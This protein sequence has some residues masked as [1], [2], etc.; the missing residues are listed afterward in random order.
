MNPAL[1]SGVAVGLG[2]S[3]RVGVEVIVGVNVLVEGIA[4]T[5]GVDATDVGE[6]HPARRIIRRMDGRG[7]IFRIA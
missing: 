7:V 6:A 5:V 2:V 3:V 1:G 4:V